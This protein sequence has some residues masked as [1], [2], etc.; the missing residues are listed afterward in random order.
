MM[1]IQVKIFII[2]IVIFNRKFCIVSATLVSL[3]CFDTGVTAR[4]FV[5]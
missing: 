5:S 3:I 4:L 1:I 2:T